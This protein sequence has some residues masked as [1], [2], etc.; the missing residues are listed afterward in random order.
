[1][2]NNVNLDC[3]YI[4]PVRIVASEGCQKADLLL[5]KTPR[6]AVFGGIE[7]VTVEKDGYIIL[8]FGREIHG[9]LNITVYNR[10]ENAKLHLTFGESVSE[11]LSSIGEKGATNDHAMRDYELELAGSMHT[12]ETENTGF[13]FVRLRAVNGKIMI[14][15]V[16]AK[17]VYRD[18][19]YYGNFECND[20]ELN[21]IWKTAAYTVQLNMQE[22]IWDGIKRDRLVW[23]GDMHPEVSTA[24]A[25]FGEADVIKDSL[26]VTMD[27]TPAG[28]WA[29]GIASYSMW[30]I[31]LQR[32]WFIATADKAYIEKN[33]EYI[34]A[35]LKSILNCINEDGSDS[36]TG[37]GLPAYFVDWSSCETKNMATGF[38]GVLLIALDA[39]RELC[40][41][42]NNSALAEKLSAAAENVRKFTPDYEDNKQTAALAALSGLID[43]KTAAEIIK[44]NGAE[45]FS[46]FMG[47]YSLLA[48][49]AAGEM[50]AALEIIKKFWGGMIKMGATTFW[51]EFDI[52]DMENSYRIDELPQEGKHDVHGDF[53][54]FCYGGLRKSLCHGWSSGPAAFMCKKVLGV[55]P[56]EPG[57]KKIRLCPDLG[58]LEW[59]KGSVPTPY[60]L[61]SV[62][63]RRENGEIKTKI[64]V[65]EGI[66]IEE[67]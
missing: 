5:T 48:L 37:G 56:L 28:H 2:K 67:G 12:F 22:Y 16:Q 19:K 31:V 20:S 30:W 6:Q 46:T 18:L 32:D 21:E 62:E 25:V 3:K 10:D 7:L 60:G 51:E 61:I 59:A 66:T 44:K 1:M 40:G 50:T 49:Q 36:F 23:I 29:N 27:S 26:D 15:G 17:F 8:D 57:Y 38:R 9:G 13:R 63:C 35:L 14:S 24:L 65:P 11:A 42:L 41:Y 47:Y 39:G 55:I 4:M 45:G 34:F 33:S 58:N 43:C 52:K 64:D 53:G 54:G